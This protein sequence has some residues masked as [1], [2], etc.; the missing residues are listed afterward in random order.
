M[1]DTKKTNK[2]I[3][4]LA[5]VYAAYQEKIVLEDIS[6]KVYQNDFIGIIG[7]NGSGKTTLLK[8]ILGL[9]P[10]R[11]GDLRFYLNGSQKISKHLGY[12][13]QFNIFD[14]NFPINVYQ[15]TLSGLLSKVNIFR[16]FTAR[17]KEKAEQIMKKMDIS[18]L[19]QKSINELSGGEK[20]RVFLSRALIS[21]PEIL[22][23]DEPSTFVDTNFNRSFYEILKE[24][25]KEMTILLVS[26]DL[27]MI[28]SYVKSIACVN[29]RIYYHDSNEITQELLN[30]Y[31]CPIDLI[32]HGHVPHRVL[33]NHG[34]S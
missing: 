9:I 20:Q 26:H 7:P 30:E 31:R 4:E 29:R 2:K 19:K 28:S 24:L 5:S 21:E 11:K 25:N 8:I 33:K 1:T 6:L 13:P 10:P 32:T 27:G 3:F 22:L 23:L 34:L 18:H 17:D 15:V 14:E 16:R 12:L